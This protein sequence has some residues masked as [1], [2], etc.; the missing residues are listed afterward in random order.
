MEECD[1]CGRKSE[2]LYL[3]EIEG[4]QMVACTECSRGAK[5]IE[6]ISSSQRSETQRRPKREREE[7]QVVDGF[8]RIIRR[9]REM[10]G[11]T[12]KALAEKINEKESTLTRV[13]EEHM[14]PEDRLAKKLEN[15][16][17]ITLIV[18]V[19]VDA[20]ARTSGKPVPMTLGDAALLKKDKNKGA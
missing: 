12:T 19:E 16:L 1:I 5:V 10:R 13:E 3:V 20:S 4:A 18:K 15:E 7:S 8:G 2:N 11:L 17:G 14:L 6:Q 9:A